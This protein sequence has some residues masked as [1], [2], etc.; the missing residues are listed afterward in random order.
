MNGFPES[1]PID[2]PPK[3]VENANGLYFR[4]T[5]NCPPTVDDF[6]SHEEMGKQQGGDECVRRGLSVFEKIEDARHLIQIFPKIGSHVYSAQLQPK[7]GKIKSTPSRNHPLI[8][9][10][11]LMLE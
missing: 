9:L 5:K 10:G 11:G 7:D 6:K 2:C 3:E 4:V 8:L 1:W